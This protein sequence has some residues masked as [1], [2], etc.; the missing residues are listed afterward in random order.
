MHSR[1]TINTFQNLIHR[2][3]LTVSRSKLSSNLRRINFIR[4]GLF[5]SRSIIA[6]KWWG[7]EAFFLLQEEE[8]EVTGALRSRF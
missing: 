8:D 3:E 4:R 1:V 7:G 5:R 2:Y 6:G